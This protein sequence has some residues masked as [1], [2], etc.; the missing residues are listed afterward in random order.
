M[1]E[2]IINKL[3]YTPIMIFLATALSACSLGAATPPPATSSVISDAY[4]AAGSTLTALAP[5]ASVTPYPTP[6]AAPA[7]LDAPRVATLF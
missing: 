3:T 7:R 4:L 5:P 2:A 6:P 1:W